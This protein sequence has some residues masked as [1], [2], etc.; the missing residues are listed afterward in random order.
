MTLPQDSKRPAGNASS[1]VTTSVAAY[2]RQIH[3]LKRQLERLRRSRTMRV[4]RAITGP[5][6]SVRSWSRRVLNGDARIVPVV[7]ETPLESAPQP[8]SR[9]LAQAEHRAAVRLGDRSNG[10]FHMHM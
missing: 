6:R 7:R 4:G 1:S 5:Y 10:L 8:K 3:D 9:G 2:E